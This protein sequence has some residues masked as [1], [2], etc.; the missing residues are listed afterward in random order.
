MACERTVA[1]CSI[2]KPIIHTDRAKKQGIFISM[3]LKYL[4]NEINE[5]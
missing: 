1:E 2:L 5:K 4:A 3:I